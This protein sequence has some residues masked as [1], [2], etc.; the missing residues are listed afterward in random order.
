MNGWWSR[1]ISRNCQEVI[2]EPGMIE[3]EE[4][5]NFIK[6]RIHKTRSK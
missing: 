6:R 1:I 3:K 5:S 2:K 4:N